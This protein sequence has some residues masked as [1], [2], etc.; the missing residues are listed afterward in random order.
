[1]P[2]VFSVARLHVQVPCI[3]TGTLSA[4]FTLGDTPVSSLLMSS[5]AL[6]LIYIIDD[7]IGFLASIRLSNHAFMAPGLYMLL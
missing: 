1:M 2:L 5:M 6:Y 3:D 7:V 4:W